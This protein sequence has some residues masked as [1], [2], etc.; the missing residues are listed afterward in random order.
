MTLRLTFLT[1]LLLGLT[2]SAA[3]AHDV[4]LTA[5]DRW[6][7]FDAH[8]GAA[9]TPALSPTRQAPLEGAGTGLELVGNLPVG[10]AS[11]LELHGNL[12]FIGS[13]TEGL[14]IADISD[15][16]KPKRVGVFDCGGGSQYDVQLRPDGKVAALTTDGSGSK[17]HAEE[18]GSMIIDVSN[19]AAPK[20]I[21][22]LEI[23]N[24][25]SSSGAR[26]SIVGSHTH[27]FDW[28]YVYIN[29]Y[30]SSYHRV[31]VFSLADPA[32]PE[33]VGELDFGAGQPAFHDSFVDHR[34]DGRTL[35]YAGS[36]SANDVIDVTDP[37]KP[38]LV[39]RVVDPEVTFSH[40]NE[41]DF[42]RNT[43][44]VTDEYLGGAAGPS[45]G[46]ADERGA[47]AT[48]GL[49]VGVGDPSDLG[50]LHLYALKPNGTMGEKLSTFNL[51][52]QPNNDPRNGCTIHVFWQAPDQDRLVTA[53]YGRG[54][55]VLDYSDARNVKELGSFIP[56]GTNMWA[57]KPHNGYIFTGDLNRGMDVLRFTGEGWP[58]TAGAAEAQ[59]LAQQKR[60]TP[61]DPSREAPRPAPTGTGVGEATPA[62]GA[63]PRGL[64]GL[65]ILSVR[66]RT[67]R[68]K[69][70]RTVVLRVT[71][72]RGKQIGSVRSRLQAGTVA[73]LRARVAGDPG[74]Y[75]YRVTSGRKTLKRGVF[76]VVGQPGVEVLVPRG[77][78]VLTTQTGR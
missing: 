59:R 51:P 39:Q 69:G 58:R 66:V 26:G 45:C 2:A 65:K 72:L 75:R 11:D 5:A 36:D 56:S 77:R 43:A 15:P 57:A 8:H 21:A 10:E 19:P 42:D 13:Y 4:Q 48:P 17:C 74:R 22:F 63:N 34:P 41:P 27:T 18:Q 23:R 29:Q 24:P 46:K 28:P 49:P 47:E 14:V 20:E 9:L 31:E 12:A 3:G 53:W 54:V 50:A 6:R 7:S 32:N 35:L 64:Q 70:R 37:T 38:K 73:R 52:S 78:R 25:P 30:Q 71:D 67:P 1:L 33:K 62:P 40:Q 76:R 44:L 55:R 68:G 60:F 61:E 16:A